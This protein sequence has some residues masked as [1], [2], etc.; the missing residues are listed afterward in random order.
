MKKLLIIDGN[1]ILNRA[2]YGLSGRNML[3]TSSGIYTNAIFGFLN[4]LNK[5]LNDDQHTYYVVAFDRK[6][7][8]FRHEIYEGYKAKRTKMPEELAM[9]MPLVKEVITSLGIKIIEKAG[10]EA[11]DIIGTVAKKASSEKIPVTVVTGDKD[12]FQLIDDNVSI[13]YTSTR[14]GIT[15]SVEYDENMFLERYGIKPEQMIDLKAIMGDSSDNIP[16]VKGIG[17]KGAIKLISEFSSLENI[18]DNIDNTGT[19]RIKKLL[20]EDKEMCFL[21]R[22]LST[23]KTNVELELDTTD[24]IRKDIDEIKLLELFEKLEFRSHIQK[25]GLSKKETV[26][27]TEK[28]VK[29]IYDKNELERLLEQLKEQ[30]ILYLF[31]ESEKIDG[32]YILSTLAIM[33]GESEIYCLKEHALLKV[34]ISS[35]KIFEIVTYDSKVLFNYSI[36]NTIEITQK[37]FDV[38]L[39]AYLLDPDEK[40]LSIDTLYYKN[41]KKVLTGSKNDQNQQISLFGE[42]GE[43]KETDKCIYVEAIKELRY[44][45]VNEMKEKDLLKL[46][47]EI[48]VPTAEVLAEIEHNGIRIDKKVL[49]ELDKKLILLLSELKSKIIEIAGVEFNL[50]SPKQLGEVL[51]EKLNLP[52]IKKTKTGYSTNADVLEV[53]RGRHE[54]IEYI[55]NY[56]QFE[57]LRST[58][59]SGLLSQISNDEKIYSTFNQKVA[60]TGRISSQDPNLQNIPIKLEQGREFRKAFVA[61][62]ANILVDADYSQIELRVLAHISDDIDM[63]KVY[64]NDDD[65]H[66]QTALYI[67]NE[68]TLD[69]ITPTMRNSA[70]TINFS[71]IYGIS[72]YSLALDLG[73]TR[74]EAQEYID[75]YFEKYPGVKKYL[76]QVIEEAKK[77]GSVSTIFGRIRYVDEINSKNFNIRSFWERVAMNTPIQGSAADIIKI[78]MIN[79]YRI[80]KDRKLKAKLVLQVHDELIVDCP[81]E[82]KELVIE[83]LKEAMQ[84]AC[85]LNVPLK[86]D[87]N[88]GKNWFETK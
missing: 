3:K 40:D 32:T 2:Y 33:L 61:D 78:A 47:N 36:D 87:I 25:F 22:E 62:E 27:E 67:F 64:I 68:E 58:Y 53:L 49:L 76:D 55:L 69:R 41:F 77:E 18:Y 13:S 44:I 21:S 34:L 19:E 88:L 51:F 7:P 82:E 39:A 12:A 30:T 35:K 57:K 14:S 10:F 5:Y 81:V 26:K 74:K 45:F 59:S 37:I 6:E 60:A 20:L 66:S 11:D 4:V 38:S 24:Y 9:Q 50:N 52:V 42:E 15:S 8:T 29:I 65:I 70:K 46:Y 43:T 31:F 84:N 86:V 54:I 28:K 63:K 48:E 79:V 17:E 16:G 1:S 80:L 23:I 71:V 73:I 85:K 72:A 56:R 83:L 75:E